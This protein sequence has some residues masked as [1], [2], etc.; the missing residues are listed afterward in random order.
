LGF[1]LARLN[2]PSELWNHCLGQRF[3]PTTIHP[4][5]L[6]VEYLLVAALGSMQLAQCSSD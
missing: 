4:A 1:L 5:R 6:A 3:L 2:T